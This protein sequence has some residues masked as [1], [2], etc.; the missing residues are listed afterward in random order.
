MLIA[1]ANGI[2]IAAVTVFQRERTLLRRERA[3]KLYSVSAYFLSKTLCDMSNNVLLP[4]LYCMAVYWT[5]N[6][7]VSFG[8][9]LRFILAFYLT[10]S[11]AQS[12]GLMVSV[13]IPSQG[14]ALALAPPFTLFFLIMGGFYIPLEK[15]HPGVEWLSWLSFARYGYSSLVVNEYQDRFIPC[16]DDAAISIG[17]TGECPLPGDEVIHSLGIKGVT[18]SF[19]FNIAV[20]IGLQLFFRVAAYVLL[21][22]SK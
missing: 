21:R 11:T 2:V 4:T 1:Q 10:V 14:L 6:Y 13:A 20:L 3:K 15:M 16:S 5:A 9:Y 12:M 18:E 7:R 19:W 22:R 8:A 17:F